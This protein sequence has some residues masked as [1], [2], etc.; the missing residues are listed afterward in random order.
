MKKQS[1]TFEQVIK[2][3]MSDRCTPAQMDAINKAFIVKQS[4][5][6]ENIKQSLKV[7]DHVS[8]HTQSNGRLIGNITKIEPATNTILI[9]GDSD[10]YI[11]RVKVEN[12]V[13]VFRALRRTLVNKD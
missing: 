12:I 5:V 9:K 2:Y 8:F 7:G 4:I 11:W 13:K 10:G 3:V 1:T 6:L